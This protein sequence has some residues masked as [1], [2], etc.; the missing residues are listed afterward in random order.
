MFWKLIALSVVLWAVAMHFSVML[1]GF[2]HLLPAAAIACIVVRQM[3]KR[4]N[5]E[6]GRWRPAS[7][8]GRRR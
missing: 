7:E 1:G 4:P 2:I 8:R 5:S 6:F 3:G